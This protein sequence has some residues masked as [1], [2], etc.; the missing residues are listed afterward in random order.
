MRD[1]DGYEGIYMID[2]SG[3]VYATRYK[4][5]KIISPFFS[6]GRNGENKYKRVSLSKHGI[7]KKYFVHRLVAETYCDGHREG[8]IVNHKDGNKTN[9]HFSNLEWV[10]YS[11]NNIHA[12]E[13]GLASGSLGVKQSRNTSGFAGVTKAGNKWKAQIRYNNEL[14]YLGVHD[15]PEAASIVYE[16]RLRTLESLKGKR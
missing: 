3:N 16:K 12:L 11:E 8:L 13:N 4:E 5:P 7:R 9:N 15:S 2:E 6:K 10:T 1:I 14:I